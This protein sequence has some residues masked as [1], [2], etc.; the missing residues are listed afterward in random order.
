MARF[1][2][3]T[4]HFDWLKEIENLF[5]FLRKDKKFLAKSAVKLWKSMWTKWVLEIKTNTKVPKA[6]TDTEAL[7]EAQVQDAFRRVDNV[8]NQNWKAYC[9]S[10]DLTT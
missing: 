8:S 4:E 2:E 9:D 6:P 3:V 5:Q 7:V 1:N 10:K